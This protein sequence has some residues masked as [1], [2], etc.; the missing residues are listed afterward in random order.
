LKLNLNQ[1]RK[2]FPPPSKKFPQLFSGVQSEKSPTAAKSTA[3]GIQ[4]PAVGLPSTLITSKFSF[5][6]LFSFHSRLL[7]GSESSK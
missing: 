6:S 3:K 7:N 4:L 1:N 2:K 5:S